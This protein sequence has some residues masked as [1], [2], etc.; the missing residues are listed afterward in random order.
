MGIP[1]GYSDKVI[2]IFSYKSIIDPVK[3][4][5]E[6]DGFKESEVY[7]FK[8]FILNLDFSVQTFTY[9]Y[10]ST[11]DILSALGGLGATIKLSLGSL[12]PLLTLRFMIEFANV[13]KRKA[14]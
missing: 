4:V 2:N 6:K 13:Q 14:E 3:S 8:L 9:E 11:L 5:K 7:E 10:F 12:V 1:F